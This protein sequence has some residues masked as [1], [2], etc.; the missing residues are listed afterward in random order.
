GVI[1]GAGAERLVN[2]TAFGMAGLDCET[3][4]MNLDLEGYAI[5]SGSACAT[6]KREPSPVLVAMGVP[7]ELAG[8]AIRISLGRGT[9]QEDVD[10]FIEALGRAIRRLAG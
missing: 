9:R 6:G 7:G 2:T 3:L 5:A 8:S 10:G 4:V 1:F